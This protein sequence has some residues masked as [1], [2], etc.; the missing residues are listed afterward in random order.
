MSTLWK[1]EYPEGNCL[2][3]MSH[4]HKGV[5]SKMSKWRG[6]I[7]GDINSEFEVELDDD[8]DEEQAKMAALEDWTFVEVEGLT[9]V[10]IERVDE[11]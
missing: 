2:L 4:L 11:E 1:L 3:A 8:A 7:K 5:D 10:D 9:V 6:R